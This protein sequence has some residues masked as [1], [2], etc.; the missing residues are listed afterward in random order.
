M[1]YLLLLGGVC[2]SAKALPVVGWARAQPADGSPGQGSRAYRVAELIK[3][4]VD[5]ASSTNFSL[6]IWATALSATTNFSLTIWATALSATTTSTPTPSGAK[7]A[8]PQSA[9]TAAA[10]LPAAAA[11]SGLSAAGSAAA[12]RAFPDW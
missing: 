3:S 6:T 2:S 4:D 7:F 10:P 5:C 9:A 1:L 12:A 8:A 11:T